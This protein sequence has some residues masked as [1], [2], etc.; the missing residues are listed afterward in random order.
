MPNATLINSTDLNMWA[1]RLESQAKLPQLLRRL[2]RTTTPDIEKLSFSSDESIQLEGFDGWLEAN[3]GNDFVPAG[4]SVWELGVS[5]NIKKKADED[6]D[7]RSNI[8]KDKAGN[9]M[10]DPIKFDRKTAIYIFVTPR[11][12]S[13]KEDWIEA[14]N[15][16]GKW[17]EVRAYDANDLEAWLEMAPA[18]HIWA[19][20]LMGK[21]LE[22]IVDI[23]NHWLEWAA[24]TNPETTPSLVLCDRHNEVKEIQSW[25]QGPASIFSLKAE[26]EQEAVAFL[27]AC[28]ESLPDGAK[29]AHKARG[30]VVSNEAEWRHLSAFTEP[31]LLVSILP[32]RSAVSFALKKGHHVFIPLGLNESAANATATLSRPNRAAVYQALAGM[33]I[34]VSRIDEL[35]TLGR[36]S[37]SALRRRLALNASAVTPKWSTHSNSCTLLPALMVGSWDEAN[38]NDCEIVSRLG[39]QDYSDFRKTCQ[40]WANVPYPFIRSVGS[41]WMVI[42]MWDSW[43]LMS[44]FITS[45][46]LLLFKEI[47]L[48]V[49]EKADP[50]LGINILM[51]KETHH[52]NVMRSGIAAAILILASQSGFNY[53]DSNNKGQSWADEII[54]ELFSKVSTWEQW[55]TLDHVLVSLAE[56]SPL[57]FLDAV[58]TI[59]TG[60]KPIAECLFEQEDSTFS[61]PL[62]TGL[63]WALETLAWS[64]DYLQRVAVQLAKLT[65]LDRDSNKA[66]KYT[67]RPKNSL[68]SI[69]RHDWPCTSASAD[70]RI[71]VIDQLRQANSIVAWNLVVGILHSRHGL[72]TETPKPTYRDWGADNRTEVAWSEIHSF[73]EMLFDRLL[74]D[75]GVDEERWASILSL[76]DRI[77]N[78]KID[79]LLIKLDE[80][81]TTS[82]VASLRG[83][84]QHELRKII[85]GHISYPES[86]WAMSS[87][88]IAK[89]RE[90]YEKLN[91]EDL[92]LLYAWQFGIE[93]NFM[94]PRGSDWKEY[95][96]KI[97]GI[98]TRS[99]LEIFKLGGINEIIRL[100][101]QSEEPGLVGLITSSCIQLGSVDAEN[102]FLRQNL[103]SD[104]YNLVSLAQGYIRA[105][106]NT[107]TNWLNDKLGSDFTKSLSATGHAKFYLSLPSEP[108]IWKRLEAAH[109]ETQEFY[110]TKVGIWNHVKLIKE[111]LQYF[112][113]QLANHD[114]LTEAIHHAATYSYNDADRLPVE[115]L[116]SLIERGIGGEHPLHVDWGQLTHEIPQLLSVIEA[117]GEISDQRLGPL[118]LLFL[119]FLDYSPY[120]PKALIRELV[121]QPS[122]FSN[123]ITL[124][125]KSD[126]E[127]EEKPSDSRVLNARKAHEI[128]LIWKTIPGMDSQNNINE[129]ELAQWVE[130]A[131]GFVH[132]SGHGNIGE[133]YIGKLLSNSPYGTD[134]QWPH[135]AIRPVI[136]AVMSEHLALGFHNGTINNR[137][138]TTRGLTEG[139]RQEREIAASYKGYALDFLGTWPRTS[140][141]LSKLAEYYEQ[142]GIQQD[143]RADLTQDN[144]C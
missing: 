138:V 33:D 70:E 29:T 106:S 22:G 42:S 104:E 64:P 115:F 136:E 2:A 53:I 8:P 87:D 112:I 103:Q 47:A 86:A 89:L 14:K 132:A 90:A 134:K 25:L 99:I 74:L 123:L 111:D 101:K 141:M 57:R 129:S 130:D 128:L 38:K 23:E 133:Y 46:D 43:G 10:D 120:Q 92:V 75:L 56:A 35:A 4:L 79:E 144:W 143:D 7:K 34:S 91:S 18:V 76:L 72:I 52:S 51:G 41:I 78:N 15:K 45:C 40:N 109:K 140:R 95:E 55:A 105:L 113:Q 48:E 54:G 31:L 94:I 73:A 67:N 77:P 135:E 82:G 88:Q 12:W 16:E 108:A 13:S 85:T 139:G 5:R 44:R 50:A 24:V 125:Y 1:S 97:L 118:E 83:V 11:R 71:R 20:I 102:E 28:I 126:N 26:T 37:L 131:K 63:L 58:D 96:E 3:K 66:G 142:L 36:R 122:L 100:A 17:R 39:R 59:L 80:V 49:L 19:S 127:D 69:F 121:A 32:D 116:M 27:S 60:H 107:E 30:L 81:S 98:R 117:S 65:V 137:G 110:W 68:I 93:K 124:A 21:S 114:R 119:S 61:R 62:H 84:I 6:Y 9:D